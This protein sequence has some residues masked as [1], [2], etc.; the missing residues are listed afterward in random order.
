MSSWATGAVYGWFAL[1]YVVFVASGGLPS[2]LRPGRRPPARV[3]LDRLWFFIAIFA[4][5]V[6]A[7]VFAWGLRPTRL[8]LS[9]GSPLSWLPLTILLS[10]V[11]AGLGL[12]SKKGNP[13]L[14]NYPQ[15]L[16]DHWTAA[17]IVYQ[18]GSWALYLFAYEFAFRGYL[19]V[20]LLPMGVPA[21]IAIHT[22]IYALAHT[23]KSGKEAGGA[24]FL[25]VI[26]SL[27]TLRWGTMIPAFIIHMALALGN[28][29]GAIRAAKSASRP[30]EPEGHS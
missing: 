27:L 26:L 12:L 30:M 23:P 1:V 19:L 16:P 21:A 20:P 10:A 5:P 4:V 2:E 29:A 6:I 15:Y 28:D 7:L 17:A 25:G 9:W 11:A 14:Q 3:L 22:A 24:L 13:D 18:V 8:L